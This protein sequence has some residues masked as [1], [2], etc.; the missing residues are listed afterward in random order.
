MK[1]FCYLL[2]LWFLVPLLVAQPEPANDSGGTTSAGGGAGASGNGFAP[3]ILISPSDLNYAVSLPNGA[4]MVLKNNSEHFNTIVVLVQTEDWLTSS[5]TFRFEANQEMS[6]APT[7]TLSP[8]KTIHVLSMQPF[9]VA[10]KD[11]APLIGPSKETILQAQVS[12]EN[13]DLN[14]IEDASGQVIPVGVMEDGS[15]HY[16]LFGKRIGIIENDA[17]LIDDTQQRFELLE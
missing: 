8:I 3:L 13:F 11:D 4:N 12:A 7:D 5:N 14:F 17:V 16:P 6:F 2:L 1:N 10:V 15:V 9:E